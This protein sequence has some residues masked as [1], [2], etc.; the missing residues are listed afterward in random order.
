[1]GGNYN[2]SEEQVQEVVKIGGETHYDCKPILTLS[3]MAPQRT[4]PNPEL[5]ALARKRDDDGINSAIRLAFGDDFFYE[6]LST[7]Q[8]K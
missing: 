4:N 7:Y 5:A 2:L 6:A 3:E 8:Q 1:M